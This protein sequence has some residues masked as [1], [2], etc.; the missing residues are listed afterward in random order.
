MVS[1]RGPRQGQRV[2]A[3]AAAVCDPVRG[4]EPLWSA[5][6]AALGAVVAVPRAPGRGDSPAGDQGDEDGDDGGRTKAGHTHTETE[7]GEP[8]VTVV[9]SACRI[10]Q[11]WRRSKG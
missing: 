6:T 1:G 7:C 8:G 11:G 2:L 3:V 4:I 9:G 5:P 10:R